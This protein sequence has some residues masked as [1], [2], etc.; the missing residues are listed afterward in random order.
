MRMTESEAKVANREGQH[1]VAVTEPGTSSQRAD[2]T[3]LDLEE[4]FLCVIV[5]RSLTMTKTD[6]KQF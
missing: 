4:A 2:S 6:A 1:A 5:R 3:A